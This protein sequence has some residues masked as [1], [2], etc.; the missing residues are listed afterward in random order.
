MRSLR[1]FSARTVVLPPLLLLMLLLLL[2]L[3]LSGC[4]STAGPSVATARSAAA[5]AADR[6][7]ILAM[8]GEF[9][10]RFEFEETLPLSAGYAL[11]ETKRSGATE[12]VEVIADR[13]DF[14][15]LQHILV[16]GDGVDKRVIKHWR[17]DWQFEPAQVLRYLGDQRWRPEAVR[18]SA[19]LGAWSQ[20][21]YE[22]DDAPR[23]G[24]VGRW[25]HADGEIVWE[26]D[27][28]WRPLPRREHTTRDDYQVMGAINRH[29]LTPDGWAHEQINTKL[30][31]D[32][33]GRA[34]P[35]V[36][37]LGSNTYTR[38][39]DFDFSAGREYWRRT[40]TYWA[41]VRALYAEA[42]SRPQGLHLAGDLD[43]TPRYAASFALAKQEA[44]G[45][46]V[47]RSTLEATLRRFW[48][49]G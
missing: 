28:S 25:R 18:A 47:S 30:T 14:I 24:G 46:P 42:L 49:D 36:R 2:L 15:S 43:G 40:A 37:E 4:A 12:F 17:Q 34:L 41:Q 9:R 20:T 27:Y 13:G 10:V 7:A 16:M 48:I 22:V 38:I 11:R 32:G 31:L 8:A 29:L 23:Y 26:S 44:E 1:S 6:A 19:R 3:L 35:L 33:E 39:A 5:P 21:V 45:E